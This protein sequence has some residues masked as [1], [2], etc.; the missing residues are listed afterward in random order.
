MNERLEAFAYSKMPLYKQWKT[1][2]GVVE[3]LLSF[4]ERLLNTHTLVNELRSTLKENNKAA[5]ETALKNIEINSVAPKLQTAV[6]T[7]RKHNS[8][9]K[10]FWNT[11]T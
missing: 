4:D 2:K 8:D 5:F 9:K 10:Y 7:L 11:V 1:P 3:H 6:K